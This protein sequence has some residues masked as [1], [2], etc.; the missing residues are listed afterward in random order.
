M[1]TAKKPRVTCLFVFV[2]AIVEFGRFWAHKHERLHAC[3]K[4]A[5]LGHQV[6]FA[7]ARSLRVPAVSRL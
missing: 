2:V 1:V 6:R 7:M 4:P 3:L 5:Y